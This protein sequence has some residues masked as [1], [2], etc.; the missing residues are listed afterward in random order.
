MIRGFTLQTA[1]PDTGKE[2]IPPPLPEGYHAHRANVRRQVGEAAALVQAK[3]LL[4]TQA[5][6][7]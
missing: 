2:V 4:K 1:R 7:I 6:M 3:E 5:I